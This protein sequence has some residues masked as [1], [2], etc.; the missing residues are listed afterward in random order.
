M[1][2]TE[3]FARIAEAL[4]ESIEDSPTRGRT[5]CCARSAPLVTDVGL[6]H[7]L[8]DVRNLGGPDLRAGRGILRQSAPAENNPRSATGAGPRPH[9]GIRRRRDALTGDSQMNNAQWR[10][11][12]AVIRGEKVTPLPVPSSSTA[13]GAE[14]GGDD[15][16]RLHT[17]ESAG[18]PATQ[19]HPGFPGLH[20]PPR[21]LV[22]VRD[23]RRTV[24]VRRQV[25]V[26]RQRVPLPEKLI[27][28]VDDIDRV[29]ST[30]SPPRR[31]AA[32]RHQAP[33]ALA[34][35]HRSRGAYGTFRRSR[36]ALN[37]ASFL[38]GTTEFLRR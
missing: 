15:D 26:L 37:I 3:K 17:S 9:P 11:W 32:V 13:R 21:L 33:E 1:A 22:G 23:V 24:R 35:A 19:G 2:A 4:G 34:A 8:A 18:W 6:P 25:P 31:L 14:L 29:N 5:A 10:H 38:M 16:S 36:A 28:S 30:R 27:Q 7:V 20:L 12:Q